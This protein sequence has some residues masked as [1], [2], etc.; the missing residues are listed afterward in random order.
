M[1]AEIFVP[2][3][4]KVVVSKISVEAWFPDNPDDITTPQNQ[5]DN[6]K[7]TLLIGDTSSFTV[8]FFKRH[9]CLFGVCHVLPTIT[10]TI[11]LVRSGSG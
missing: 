8:G 5:H 9:V 10:M 3:S 7:E 6:G 1:Y 4:R 11:S 2:F